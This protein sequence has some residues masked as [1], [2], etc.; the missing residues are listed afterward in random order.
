M[1]K[2]SFTISDDEKAFFEVYGNYKGLTVSQLAKVALFAYKE[3]YPVKNMQ[4]PCK[5]DGCTADVVA[6]ESKTD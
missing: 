1:A 3:R 2:V 6:D 5:L 4:F